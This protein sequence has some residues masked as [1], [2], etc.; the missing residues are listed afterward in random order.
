MAV[1]GIQNTKQLI[2]KHADN[3]QKGKVDGLMQILF[4]YKKKN[5]IT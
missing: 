4:Y 5:H 2:C 3:L 1:N